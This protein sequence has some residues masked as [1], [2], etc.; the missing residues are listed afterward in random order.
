MVSAHSASAEE[1]G[2]QNKVTVW[3]WIQAV[4]AIALLNNWFLGLWLV[5]D[6]EGSADGLDQCFGAR[7]ALYDG[8]VWC[9]HLTSA[10]IQVFFVSAKPTL[11][12]SLQFLFP[13]L[14]NL[15]F[16]FMFVP[17]L[18]FVLVPSVSHGAQG[19]YARKLLSDLME[20]Y[21]NALRPVEDTD[22]A[23]NVS[24]QI[25]LSQIKDMVSRE[26]AWI[27]IITQHR[28]RDITIA[29]PCHRYPLTTKNLIRC[30]LV[31]FY[32]FSKIWTI[33]TIM[34]GGL[35]YIYYKAFILDCISFIL[36]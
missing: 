21:S 17:T 14:C 11:P 9:L 33:Q 2:D 12:L 32:S 1:N 22:K 28:L 31:C 3:I 23:L 7:S 27:P 8:S 18:C 20:N 34:K 30:S 4:S 6:E 13:V 19:H 24:L 16:I 10:H 29:Q 35:H 5:E 25:T 15:Y 26:E 36:V